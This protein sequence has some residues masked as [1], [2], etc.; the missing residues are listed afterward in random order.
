M[1]FHNQT[2]NQIIIQKKNKTKKKHRQSCHWPITC[3]ELPLVPPDR[4]NSHQYWKNRGQAASIPPAAVS[5]SR[6]ERWLMFPYSPSAGSLRDGTQHMSTARPHPPNSTIEVLCLDSRHSKI[7]TELHINTENIQLMDNMSEWRHN[8]ILQR[9]EQVRVV[10]CAPPSASLNNQC[11]EQTQQA[12]G[13]GWPKK[14]KKKKPT[15]TTTTTTQYGT[16]W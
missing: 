9:W 14:K 3:H 8:G 5:S 6:E 7:D 12:G 4:F 1:G 13:C 11:R 16:E 10:T 2:V 15:T